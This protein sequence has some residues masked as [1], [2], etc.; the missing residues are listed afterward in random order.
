MALWTWWPG[1]AL[2]DLGCL[3]NFSSTLESGFDQLADFTGLERGEVEARLDDGKRCYIG[4]LGGTAV[5]YAW[6][7][8]SSALIVSSALSCWREPWA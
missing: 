6:V 5:A 8:A 2:P 1:D 4:W 7:A 3:T